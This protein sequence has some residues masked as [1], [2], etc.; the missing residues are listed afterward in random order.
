[1][2]SKL[3]INPCSRYCT[4]RKSDGPKK[5]ELTENQTIKD[6]A[7]LPIRNGHCLYKAKTDTKPGFKVGQSVCRTKEQ[8]I[9]RY[10]KT[11]EEVIQIARFDLLQPRDDHNI[12]DIGRKFAN[13]M[14]DEKNGL[15]SF[16]QFFWS[17]VETE[18]GDFGAM[19][20]VGRLLCEAGTTLE[21][22]LS[23]PYE[24]CMFD[25]KCITERIDN[26]EAAFKQYK[27]TLQGLLDLAKKNGTKVEIIIVSSW[28][29]GL[30]S[31]QD[32]STIIAHD[33]IDPDEWYDTLPFAVHPNAKGAEQIFSKLYTPSQ[34]AE[35]LKRFI[36]FIK[37]ASRVLVFMLLDMN[38]LVTGSEKKSHALICKE[39]FHLVGII[40]AKE[41]FEY[42]HNESGSTILSHFPLSTAKCSKPEAGIS[43]ERIQLSMM[44]FVLIEFFKVCV[45]FLKGNNDCLCCGKQRERE[46]TDP[47]NI[48]QPVSHC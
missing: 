36:S 45:S 14:S 31:Q 37:Y 32:A 15:H 4:N 23:N 39:G 43:N 17:L 34:I 9:Q 47:N 20:A 11:N 25:E 27:S 48:K 40:F 42:K 18:Y 13:A 12:L 29:P 30:K 33:Y 38:Q 3:L 5:Y 8:L 44:R 46:S 41:S 21:F 16:Q 6:Y 2:D 22:G 10:G 24:I 28:K 1:M 19:K 7:H 26:V 35:G